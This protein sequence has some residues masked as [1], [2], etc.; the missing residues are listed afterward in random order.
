VPVRRVA[1]FLGALLI[2][3]LDRC[4]PSLLV[5]ADRMMNVQQSAVTGIAIG[6]QRLAHGLG[7]SLHAIE[8]L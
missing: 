7:D 2:L 1:A 6:D 4:G 5:A 3:E 8:H